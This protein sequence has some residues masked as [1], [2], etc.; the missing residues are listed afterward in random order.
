MNLHAS[1]LASL[2]DNLFPNRCYHSFHIHSKIL[3]SFGSHLLVHKHSLLLFDHLLVFNSNHKTTFEVVEEFVY[4]FT[5]EPLLRSTRLGLD[6]DHV[7]RSCLAF[8]QLS[9]D[10][11]VPECKLVRQGYALVDAFNLNK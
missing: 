4:G 5:E 8:G 7:T 2:F 9:H 1:H 10:L 11:D 6:D 3:S